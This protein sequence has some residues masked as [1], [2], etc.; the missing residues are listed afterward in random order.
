MG[1]LYENTLLGGSTWV[2][3]SP[4]AQGSGTGSFIIS[5]PNALLI[6]KAYLIAGCCGIPTSSL[7]VTLNNGFSSTN[8]TFSTSTR[9]SQGFTTSYQNNSGLS[10]VHA[11]DVTSL[12]SL[13]ATNYTLTVPTQ[14]LTVQRY[15]DFALAIE[16]FTGVGKTTTQWFI[17]E[18]NM[19]ANNS[20]TLNFVDPIDNTL[21]VGMGLMTGY[22]CNNNADKANILVNATLLGTIGST[23]GDG[24]CGGSGY[25][26]PLGNYRYDNST[27]TAGANCNN[28]QAVSGLD[29]LSNIRTLVAL[30][31]T[32]Y[33]L[34]FNGFTAG[35]ITNNLWAIATTYVNT[36]PTYE[37]DFCSLLSPTVSNITATTA[38]ISWCS[39]GGIVNWEN[40]VQHRAGGTTLWTTNAANNV[41]TYTIT[42]LTTNTAYEFRIVNVDTDGAVCQPTAIQRFITA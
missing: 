25:I 7:T 15:T 8:F 12:I 28:N 11:I 30:N 6:T 20:R 21:P 10:S 2:G 35:N 36:T 41:S 1:V 14:S 42:G 16:Y 24:A 17:N 29:A 40:N 38:D 27:L 31:D 4:T 32:T 19:A 3:W 37:C 18:S 5:L 34:Q 9:V 13:T 23:T 22:V 39:Q 33:A 26:S